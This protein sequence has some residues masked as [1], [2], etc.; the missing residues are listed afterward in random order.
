VIRNLLVSLN[1]LLNEVAT[2]DCVLKLV[3]TLV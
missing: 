1:W 3:E 2:F